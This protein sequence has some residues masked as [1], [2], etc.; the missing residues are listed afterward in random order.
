MRIDFRTRA[1]F[2]A[3]LLSI[4]L[5]ATATIPEPTNLSA[6]KQ[7]LIQYHDS[8]RYYNRISHAIRQA[9]SYLRFRITQNDRLE[10]P[11][12][13]ALVLDIDE[14]SL[15]NYS[16]MKH[17]DFGGTP[18]D[19]VTDE[20]DAHDPAIP[21]TRTL[22]DFA[23]SHGVAVFFITGRK[24][25]LRSGT[26]KNLH[27]VGYKNWNGLFMSPTDYNGKSMVSYKIAMRKKITKMGY[28]IILNI[29]D[30]LGDLKGGYA[31]MAFKL[32]NPYY[33]LS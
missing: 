6:I 13:L 27:N 8:G 1:I 31:D 14:T 15:S 9:I 16:D 2:T 21:Y 33:S 19:I 26:I 22:F 4:A 5:N 28:D 17:R 32:P 12:K 24:E 11:R 7:Q 20:A 23:K 3:M 25:N 29:G 18:E 30:Q 10:D